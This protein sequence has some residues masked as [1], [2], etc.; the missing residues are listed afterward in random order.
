MINGS[1]VFGLDHDMPDA[2]D[3]TVDWAGDQGITK[4]TFYIATP[5]PG[6]AYYAQLDSLN[7]MWT[8]K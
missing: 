1:I 8:R 3:R 6:A 2:F 5:Y 4:P 7:R